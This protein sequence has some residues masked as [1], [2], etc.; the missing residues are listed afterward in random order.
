M[1]R[2]ILA[3]IDDPTVG[4]DLASGEV[5][6]TL[7]IIVSDGVLSEKEADAI[8]GIG[9]R[10]MSIGQELFGVPVTLDHIRQLRKGG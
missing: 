8:V 6:E 1:Y 3:M 9:A 5:P 7:A 10:P 2:E 4:V